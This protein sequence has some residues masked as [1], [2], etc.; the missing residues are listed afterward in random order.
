MPNRVIYEADGHFCYLFQSCKLLFRLKLVEWI[1]WIN[2]LNIL[3][4]FMTPKYIL[5]TQWKIT[6]CSV[7]SIVIVVVQYFYFSCCQYYMVELLLLSN[8]FCWELY[9]VYLATHN[10]CLV[11]TTTQVNLYSSTRCVSPHQY[12][13]FYIHHCGIICSHGVTTFKSAPLLGAII[14]EKERCM[15]CWLQP[16]H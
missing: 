16:V 15:L 11:V 1:E 6:K 13:T 9:T 12:Y 2:R 4:E 3:R 10:K 7:T 5:W 14:L 8:Q